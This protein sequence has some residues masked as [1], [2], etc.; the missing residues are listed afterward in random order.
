MNAP[1]RIFV[2]LGG[3]PPTAR[4]LGGLAAAALLAGCAGYPIASTRVDPKSPIAAEVAKLS[5]QNTDYPSFNEI[6]AI[7]TDVTPPKVL[8]D[9]AR[10]LDLA[11][12][13][14]D[15]ATAP[16]TWTL[17]NTSGFASRAHAAAGP[18]LGAPANTDTEAFARAARKRAT[19]PPPR[20]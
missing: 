7:P 9:R 13:Q 1:D 16:G 6:P 20:P 11:G 18:D 15:Q 12:A 19:P 10:A 3:Q 17:D 14:L 5:T 2:K 8:G 4:L